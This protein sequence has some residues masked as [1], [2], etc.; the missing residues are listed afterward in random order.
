MR[1]NCCRHPGCARPPLEALRYCR[2]HEADAGAIERV[3]KSLRGG[4]G[5]TRRKRPQGGSDA[6]PRVSPSLITEAVSGPH[7]AAGEGRRTVP[8]P[9]RER[10]RLM[11]RVKSERKRQG[12]SHAELATTA[13]ISKRAL[14]YIEA[15]GKRPHPLTRRAL[16]DALGVSEAELFP[17][18]LPRGVSV[19]P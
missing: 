11:E 9:R 6:N 4:R 3:R 8:S 1:P 19:S 5:S 16:S 10:L 7:T 14:Q 18:L 2:T 15:E 12:L 17:D 13:G